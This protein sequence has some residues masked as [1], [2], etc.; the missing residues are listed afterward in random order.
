ML[1]ANECSEENESN[2]ARKY[3]KTLAPEPEGRGGREPF[4]I[5]EFN[6]W[7]RIYSFKHQEF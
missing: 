4:W 7:L 1:R 2:N 3:N 5:S 6:R